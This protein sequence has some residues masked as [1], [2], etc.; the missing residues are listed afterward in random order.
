MLDQLTEH[1]A[2]PTGAQSALGLDRYRGLLLERLAALKAEVGEIP[3]EP[4]PTWLDHP[5]EAVAGPA[6]PPPTAVAERRTRSDGPRVLL[7]GHLDTVHDPD[8]PFREL[9][10]QPNKGIAT[11]P[12]C[13][14][15]KG[16]LLI[17]MAA[18][19][20]LAEVSVDL[21]WTVALNSD[22]ETGSFHS[23][24]ALRELAG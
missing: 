7:V 11:G 4:R 10:V 13:V 1:V 20:A 12:G 14:D 22:E 15:M 18:L 24:K 21:N 19:E 8:G 23:E 5:S 9:S 3:G 6:D 2:I 17:A 16:G